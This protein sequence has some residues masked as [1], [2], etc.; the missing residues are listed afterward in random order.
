MVETGK[1][2][3]DNLMQVY[4][5]VYDQRQKVLLVR[6]LSEVYFAL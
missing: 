2:K 3:V 1:K 5:Q 6:T 4:S